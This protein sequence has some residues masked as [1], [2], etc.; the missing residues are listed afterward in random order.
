MMIW[1]KY[2]AVAIMRHSCCVGIIALEVAFAKLPV[3][4]PAR[5]ALSVEG[6]V[7]T[8]L[9]YDVADSVVAALAYD[10]QVR[11]GDAASLRVGTGSTD[12]TRGDAGSLGVG[13]LGKDNAP[14]VACVARLVAGAG[15]IAGY[16]VMQHAFNE[17]N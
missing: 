13:N 16:L 6:S 14:P 7:V 12:N 2:L 17:F 15:G 10:N 3:G 4:F 8:A 1:L 9:A 5:K 11:H